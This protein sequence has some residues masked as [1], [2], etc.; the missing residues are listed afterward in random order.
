[1][2]TPLC[3]VNPTSEL[4]C[5]HP[6]FQPIT[7]SFSRSR[8]N[9]R[10][11]LMTASTHHPGPIP[12][13][14]ACSSAPMDG[15]RCLSVHR[16]QQSG[17]CVSQSSCLVRKCRELWKHPQQMGQQM[18]FPRTVPLCPTSFPLSRQHTP[19][20]LGNTLVTMSEKLLKLYFGSLYAVTFQLYLL[21]QENM[22]Q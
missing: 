12:L 16:I 19:A 15:M 1:M 22:W 18:I 5:P 6:H 4:W 11:F 9:K 20:D 10:A 2:T 8:S 3:G 17:Y 21:V 14:S 13:S 7:T